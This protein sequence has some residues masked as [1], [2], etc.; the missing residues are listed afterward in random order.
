MND[1]A[2]WQWCMTMTDKFLSVKSIS[3]LIRI[4]TA[5]RICQSYMSVCDVKLLI[6]HLFRCIYL[7]L[8]AYAEEIVIILLS[9][10]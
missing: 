3:F 4:D 10:L 8:S 2:V 5:Y 9:Y 7:T 1:S 6:C